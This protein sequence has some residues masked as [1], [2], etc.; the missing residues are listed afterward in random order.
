M[1]WDFGARNINRLKLCDLYIL[2]VKIL[3]NIIKN[4]LCKFFC[5]GLSIYHFALLIFRN[6][7]KTILKSAPI[8]AMKTNDSQFFL[9]AIKDFELLNFLD[10][11][12]SEK[13]KARSVSPALLHLKASPPDLST[14]FHARQCKESS[15]DNKCILEKVATYWFYP[16]APANADLVQTFCDAWH[17]MPHKF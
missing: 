12:F 1:I 2:W 11:H 16:H 7:A 9:T 14:K 15:L 17:N 3:Q 4:M 6:H 13:W 5:A 10:L 8:N